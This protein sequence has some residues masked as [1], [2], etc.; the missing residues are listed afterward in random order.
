MPLQTTAGL[1]KATG[2]DPLHPLHGTC[3]WIMW[4]FRP[5][6]LFL[7][8]MQS[9][10]WVKSFSPPFPSLRVLGIGSRIV[11]KEF[12]EVITVA[13]G[14]LRNKLRIGYKAE[15][16]RRIGKEKHT[17][18]HSTRVAGCQQQIAIRF[19][20]TCV[21]RCI[22]CLLTHTRPHARPYPANVSRRLHKL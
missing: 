8:C 1:Q 7:R 16:S 5:L 20:S 14:V 22:L 19:F 12:G 13:D 10:I 4:G 21:Q 6:C 3:R 2:A 9:L 17:L 18:T 11:E 15:C